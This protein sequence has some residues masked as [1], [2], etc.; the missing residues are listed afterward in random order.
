[1]PGADLV[2][3]EGLLD[4]L[5]TGQQ[6]YVRRNLCANGQTLMGSYETTCMYL[7]KGDADAG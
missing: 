3:V 4:L 1:M 5:S 6:S 2:L 7:V